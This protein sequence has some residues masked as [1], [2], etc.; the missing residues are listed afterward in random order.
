MAARSLWHEKQSALK[1]FLISILLLKCCWNI[2]NRWQHLLWIYKNIV[3]LWVHFSCKH[4]FNGK[5]YQWSL[6]RWQTV[7]SYIISSSIAKMVFKYFQQMATLANSSPSA[8]SWWQT[9]ELTG[10][11]FLNEGGFLG[12]A[13]HMRSTSASGSQAPWFFSTWYLVFQFS[14]Q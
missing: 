10:P 13:G 7:S 14:N 6:V 3:L 8:G 12:F 1:W 9:S 2:L 11:H 4:Q 5:V